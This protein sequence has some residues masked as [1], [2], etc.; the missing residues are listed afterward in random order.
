MPGT[1]HVIQRGTSVFIPIY[2]IQHDTRYYPDPN[3]FDPDRFNDE[4]LRNAIQ[5]LPFGL[6]P[7]N[8]IGVRFGMMQTRV[9]LVIV[10]NNFKVSLC[11]KT[12]V[13][14]AFEPRQFILTPK[15]GIYLKFK[16]I[17]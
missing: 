6:G 16:A 2:A 8:C 13:P 12:D 11:S 15:N 10:L 14:L 9:A 3:K 5:W 1:N 17:K 4:K 7:R